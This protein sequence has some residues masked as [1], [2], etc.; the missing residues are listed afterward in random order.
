MRCGK[1]IIASGRT[2]DHVTHQILRITSDVEE[3][4]TS[5]KNKLLESLMGRKS[6]TM[7]VFYQL[8]TQ[9]NIWLNIPCGYC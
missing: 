6:N 3:F 4:K 7:A 9:R 1:D 5:T 2:F 8:L